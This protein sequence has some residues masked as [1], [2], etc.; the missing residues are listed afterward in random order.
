MPLDPNTT[1]ASPETQ[2]SILALAEALEARC[3]Y[4]DHHELEPETRKLF[5]K[6]YRALR[7]ICVEYGLDDRLSWNPQPG[8]KFQRKVK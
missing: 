3:Y 6:C 8:A 2:H 7:L 4:N 1:F 5:T